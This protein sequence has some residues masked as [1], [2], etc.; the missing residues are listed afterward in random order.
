MVGTLVDPSCD[1]HCRNVG[2]VDSV[3]CRA[4]QCDTQEQP[5]YAFRH[6]CVWSVG[7]DGETVESG[8]RE[9]SR[10]QFTVFTEE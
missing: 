10:V 3:G 5:P 2:R 1:S 8:L 6:A 9:F 4:I 7:E